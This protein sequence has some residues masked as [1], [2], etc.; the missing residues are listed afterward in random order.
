MPQSGSSGWR[1]WLTGFTAV[2]LLIGLVD[3][4]AA[5][6][7][8]RSFDALVGYWAVEKNAC[9]PGAWLQISM[10]TI[11]LFGETQCAVKSKTRIGQPDGDAW[12]L[13]M[14]CATVDLPGSANVRQIFILDLSEDELYS[15]ESSYMAKYIRCK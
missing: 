4:V 1:R 2:I 8:V 15:Y 6:P 5:Q 10:K 9:N 11:S 14:R 3:F 12:L 13:N 7:K